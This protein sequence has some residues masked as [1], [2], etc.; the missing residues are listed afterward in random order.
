MSEERGLIVAP[1]VALTELSDAEIEARLAA[2]D[3]RPGG[4][5]DLTAADLALPPRMRVSQPNRPITLAN[6]E[7]APPGTFV[8][9]FTGEVLG[10]TVETV[11]L[12]F[13]DDT[14]VMWPLKFSTDNDPECAS[15]DAARP[16]A[17]TDFRPLTN[18]QVGPCASCPF[19]A[20]GDEESPRCKFQR[21]FLLWLTESEEPAILTV[22]STALKPAKTLSTLGVR[23]KMRQTVYVSAMEMKDDRG[24]WYV[25][26]Y[27]KG[28][29]LDAR[30]ALF[31]HGEKDA[32]KDIV[33]RADADAIDGEYSVVDTAPSVT[34]EHAEEEMPF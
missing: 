27:T 6:G 25:P 32:L 22:Q 26:V 11:L 10:T 3:M 31:L 13:L 2:L 14:R 4:S 17:P 8:N 9:T 34:E 21:N 28:R 19:A 23:A 33:I 18:P 29:R 24:N 15:D 12:A 30:T 1:G 5:D 7:D 20:W 16:S